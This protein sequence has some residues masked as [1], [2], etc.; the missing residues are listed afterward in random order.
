[1]RKH[2]VELFKYFHVFFERCLGFDKSS[3][4]KKKKKPFN[5]FPS[6]VELNKN[7]HTI[8]LQ[9]NGI[10][11]MWK[12]TSKDFERHWTFLH[13]L[14]FWWQQGWGAGTEDGERKILYICK[15]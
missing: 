11:F 13:I 6:Y 1:M 14:S 3:L 7:A 10:C 9:N 4:V 8:Y 2:D 5:S 15:I 12:I